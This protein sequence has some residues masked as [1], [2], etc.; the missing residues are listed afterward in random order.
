MAKY[1]P[2]RD[3]LKA[4]GKDEVALSFLEI[5]GVLGDTLPQSA[6]DHRAWWA[7]EPKG[8]HVQARAWLDAGYR[9]SML[10]RRRPA[11]SDSAGRS[12]VDAASLR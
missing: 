8:R 11:V 4:C 12:R 6:D 9:W 2:L 1:D 7:N 3:W 5:E 10:T